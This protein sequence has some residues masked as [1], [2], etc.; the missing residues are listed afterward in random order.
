MEF[1]KYKCPVCN[2]FFKPGDDVVVCPE[3][4]AP[5]H[6]E[7][8]ENN[9][10]CFFDD[11]HSDDFSF[12]ELNDEENT[13]AD[14]SDD[15]IIICPNCKSENP[16]SIFY[17]KNCGFPLNEQDRNKNAGTNPHQQQPFQG[18]NMPPFGYQGMG[19]QFDPMAGLKNDQPIAENVTA[20]EMAKFVGKNTQYY[21]RIFS[22]IKN[23]GNSRF[24]FSAFLFSGVY[25]LYR[26]MI[27]LGIIFSL[28]M[29][30]L[31]VADIFVRMMPAYQELFY[32]VF[33]AQ[34]A[35][36]TMYSM[37]ALEGLTNSEIMFLYLP[38][39][40]TVLKGA[41]MIIC[42]FIANR[43]YYKYCTKKINK[44][45][46]SGS[47]DSSKI[48]KELEAKGGV[49]LPLAVCI[50]AAYIAITYIPVFL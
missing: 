27:G 12:E 45:K 32:S 13:K 35:A 38:V 4:G 36:Q 18:Q 20:G 31:N 41:V 5:H 2:E 7:C 24:N 14:S 10:K 23:F 17:C 9:G 29:I 40:F 8:Y 47:G 46:K 11:K 26:K 44:I 42:G 1:T 50:A 30:S 6:R 21:L 19:I 48:N 33:S 34:N 28:L 39:V 15:S 37:S 49:N 3:C 25:F 22:N 43:S 16:K